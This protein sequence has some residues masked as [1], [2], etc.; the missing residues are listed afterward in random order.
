M[1]TTLTWSSPGSTSDYVTTSPYLAGAISISVSRASV[2]NAAV[3]V[4]CTV[5]L[6]FGTY[7][8]ISDG[9]SYGSRT[10]EGFTTNL[11]ASSV[12]GSPLA[13]GTI[14]PNNTSWY[15][16]SNT[17]T[18]MIS[19]IPQTAYPQIKG[20]TL[21]YTYSSWTSG[22]KTFAVNILRAGSSKVTRTFTLDCP[23]YSSTQYT[24]TFKPNGGSGTMPPQSY[25]YQASGTDNY[26][27]LNRNTFTRTGYTYKGYWTYTTAD[28]ASDSTDKIADGGKYYRHNKGNKTLYAQWTANTYTIKYDA[29]GGS[30]SMSNTSMTYDVAKNLRANAFTRSNY[31]FSH[32]NT[33]SDGSGDYSFEDGQSVINIPPFSGTITLYAIWVRQY[34]VSYNANG[35]TGAPATS[36]PIDTGS[37]YTIP[38]PPET[39]LP[40]RTAYIFDCWYSNSSGTGGT[41]YNPGQTITITSNKTLY[42]KWK[43][44]FT[45]RYYYW[46]SNASPQQQIAYEQIIDS[47]STDLWSGS[48]V[49]SMTIS[50]IEYV[51]S[52][53]WE[54]ISTAPANSQDSYRRTDCITDTFVAPYDNVA[55]GEKSGITTDLIYKAVYQPK[56]VLGTTTFSDAVFIRTDRQ[57]SFSAFKQLSEEEFRS[58]SRDNGSYICGYVK[59]ASS[60]SSNSTIRLLSG[61][62]KPVSGLVNASGNSYKNITIDGTDSYGNTDNAEVYFNGNSVYAYY[63]VSGISE[64]ITYYAK[65]L[66]NEIRNDYGATVSCQNTVVLPGIYY[67]ADISRDGKMVAFGGTAFDNVSTADPL[68]ISKYTDNDY[69]EEGVTDAHPAKTQIASDVFAVYNQF[70]V[71]DESKTLVPAITDGIIEDEIVLDSNTLITWKPILSGG[72][73]APGGVTIT[74]LNVTSNGTYTAPVGQAFSPVTVNVP[75]GGYTPTYSAGILIFE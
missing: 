47:G 36:N 52:G 70:Y 10:S 60:Y 54:S 25:Y 71:A 23:T 26:I 20:V 8:E 46:N 66:F 67:I 33:K 50:G 31:R 38:A 35:G 55:G 3:T 61:P 6:G 53:Y 30:G 63:S 5:K 45:L 28:V 7:S 59:F 40:T 4:S 39:P 18:T 51:F 15:R 11:Y 9:S 1:A 41:A 43:Q 37:Q 19:G 72:M 44:Q 62:N 68:P 65:T 29:N 27:T 17:A 56:S 75:S 69:P 57:I 74:S 24:L 22:S 42:A 2:S 64:T 13:S 14:N 12:S 49:P 34:T 73:P 21:T 48:T 32:W 58:L 16:N